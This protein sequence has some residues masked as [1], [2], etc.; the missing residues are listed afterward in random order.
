MATITVTTLISATESCNDKVQSA[1]QELKEFKRHDQHS[2]L[3]NKNANRLKNYIVK[4][5]EL[6]EKVNKIKS[7]C[8]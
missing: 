8:K 4:F 6:T 1:I 3:L 7:T 2:G 5:K